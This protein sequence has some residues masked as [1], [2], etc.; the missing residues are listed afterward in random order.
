MSSGVCIKVVYHDDGC[1]LLNMG[2]IL[3]LFKRYKSYLVVFAFTV[4][5][6]GL[7]F[8]REVSVAY[9]FG[10]SSVSDGLLVGLAPISLL[11]GLIGMA[12]AN[13]AMSQIKTPDNHEMIHLSFFPVIFSALV[14]ALVFLF[15]NQIIVSVIAPGLIGEGKTLAEQVV[16]YSSV[17][18]GLGFVYYWFRGIR[19]LEGHFTRASMAELMPNIGILIG[20]FVLYKIIGL[21]GIALGITLGYLLQLCFVFDRR[22]INFSVLS[23]AGLADAKMKTIY[24][25]ALFGALGMSG[26]IIDLFVDR[27]FASSLAEG[28]IASINFAYKVMSLPLYTAVFP[29]LIVLFPKLIAVRDEPVVFARIRIKAVA[30]LSALALS[31]TAI[32]MLLSNEI[33]SLL[34]QYGEFSQSDVEQ[35]APLLVIYAAGLIAHAY[36]L[37][38]CR[39]SYALEDFKTP[40]MAGLVAAAV[41]GGL[42]FLLVDHYGASGLAAATSVAAA[43]NAAI[44]IFFSGSHKRRVA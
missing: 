8:G 21:T 26:V 40:L 3:G 18:A 2:F 37:F 15:F 23:H 9:L 16:L 13:A 33:I 4:V 34:F 27:Y 7:G 41:N 24:K 19:H 5:G 22:K 35:T 44:L 32:F 29:V 28:S 6:H 10:A 25:N 38:A 20:I 39:V 36:V 30:V 14:I 43:V 11:I 31:C 1:G 42:D 17:G 12:Y